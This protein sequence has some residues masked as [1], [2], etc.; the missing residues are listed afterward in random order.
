MLNKF[1]GSICFGILCLV[2]L[3]TL[4]G[5]ASLPGGFQPVLIVD[6][7]APTSNDRIGVT[8]YYW[9][10]IQL[11]PP[12]VTYSAKQV[13]IELSSWGDV[14]P[15]TLPPPSGKYATA[16]LD[17]L[18]EGSYQVNFVLKNYYVYDGTTSTRQNYSFPPHQIVVGPAKNNDVAD[19]VEYYH[20]GFDHYFLT[21]AP[22]EIAALDAGRFP[23]WARTGQRFKVYASAMPGTVPVCRYYL[24]PSQGDSHFFGVAVVQ[25]E[26]PTPYVNDECRVIEKD[27]VFSKGPYVNFVKETANAFYVRRP[28]WPTGACP[29]GDLSVYRLWNNR[30]DTNHRYT[31]DP[32][33]RAQMVA[34]GYVAEGYGPAGVVMCVPG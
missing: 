19:A 9:S 12:N 20:A 7:T 5:A 15:A 32:A 31:T 10:D 4:C 21:A 6:P 1:M 30:P 29:A 2:S 13:T 8:A 33:I 16:W 27:A 23:G 11:W 18:P 26:L 22:G 24:P 14:F 28:E 34:K 3:N 25:A 17:P